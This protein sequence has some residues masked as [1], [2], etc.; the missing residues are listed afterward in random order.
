VFELTLTR[1]DVM[2]GERLPIGSL[3]STD[4]GTQLLM[5][6]LGRQPEGSSM[7][8]APT[9]LRVAACARH[10]RISRLQVR[11]LVRLGEQAGLFEPGPPHWVIPTRR[12]NDEFGWILAANLQVLRI[13]ADA[14]TRRRLPT[15]LG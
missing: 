2:R 6:L 5:Y 7:L 10:A 3:M 4:G 14:L 15:Q 1:P 9:L 12:L 13:T 8:L 11:R